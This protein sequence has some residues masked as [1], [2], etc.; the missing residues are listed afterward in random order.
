MTYPE[1]RKERS[2]RPFSSL[3]ICARKAACVRENLPAKICGREGP[4]GSKTKDL[5]EG[6][7]EKRRARER[8]GEGRWKARRRRSRWSVSACLTF[9]V[10]RGGERGRKRAGG[11]GEHSRV[12]SRSFPGSRQELC[13]SGVQRGVLESEVFPGGLGTPGLL[14]ASAVSP[15]SCGAVFPARRSSPASTM[16]K[17]DPVAGSALMMKRMS[18]S[19]FLTRGSGVSSAPR[20]SRV[21]FPDPAARRSCAVRSRGADP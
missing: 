15:A 19:A 13:A 2:F 6:I 7:G 4:L 14:S 18:A 12:I 17:A 3:G 5:G 20:P 11:S 21:L 9:R 8:G 10:L 16:K 1:G